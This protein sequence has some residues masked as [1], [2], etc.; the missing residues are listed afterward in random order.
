MR[1][2]LTVSRP[3]AAPGPA[4]P[5]DP[6]APEAPGSCGGMPPAKAPPHGGRSGT[7]RGGDRWGQ[8][9]GV[10]RMED[11]LGLAEHGH[12]DEHPAAEQGPA[13]AATVGAG[14][15]PGQPEPRQQTGEG[16]GDEPRDLAADD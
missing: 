14:G 7:C 13:G 8:R 15:P 3:P 5:A 2:A 4:A 6:G 12:L 1:P 11:P 16:E 10:V 9:D